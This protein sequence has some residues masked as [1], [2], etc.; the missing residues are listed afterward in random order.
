MNL[1]ENVAPPLV[2][3]PG[4]SKKIPKWA[5]KILESAQ[6][7]EVGKT[8][9]R[10]STRKDDGG[11]ADNS[12]DDMDVSFDCELNLST[13][14]DPNSFEEVSIFNEWKE[15]IHMSMMHS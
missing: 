1:E 15:S 12:G 5:I 8:G 3:Q 6:P 11:E 13:V 14:F 7:N 2:D 9:T 10:N 4:P